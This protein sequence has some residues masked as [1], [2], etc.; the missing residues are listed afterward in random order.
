MAQVGGDGLFQEVLNAVLMVRARA[1]DGPAQL[2][3]SRVH[4]AGGR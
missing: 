1:G 2:R 4:G 3:D